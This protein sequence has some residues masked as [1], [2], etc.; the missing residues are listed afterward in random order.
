MAFWDFKEVFC[1]R[2]SKAFERAKGIL[3]Q[4]GITFK[5]R[6]IGSHNIMGV[7]LS[8]GTQSSNIQYYLYVKKEDAEE[9]EFLIRK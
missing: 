1:G 5:S 6:L 2:D 9:A 7:R 3:E 4:N 8:G